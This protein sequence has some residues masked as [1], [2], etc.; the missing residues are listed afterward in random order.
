VYPATDRIVG[1][2]GRAC[3]VLIAVL[4]SSFALGAQ[5]Q[6][7]CTASGLMGG[8]KF[9]ANNCAVALSRS[10]HSVAIWFNEDAIS[11]QDA[12]DFQASATVDAEKEGKRRT[13]MLIT[14]CPGGGA[15]VASPGAV[16]SMGLMTNHAKS[17]LAGIQWNV[18][19]P[20][21]FKVENMTG[22]VDPGGKLAGK[23]VGKWHKTAWNLTFEVELPTTDAAQ[24]IDCAA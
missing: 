13:F 17:L 20:R 22:Q 9:A 1:P 14:L 6:N 3:R 8:L 15:A 21:D 12:K 24:G 18:K 2:H 4:L 16:K 11:S 7:K 23:I 5:A 10:Q 19:S